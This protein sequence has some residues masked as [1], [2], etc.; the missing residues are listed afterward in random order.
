MGGVRNIFWAIKANE[1]N[2]E[3]L[4]ACN[5]SIEKM[6]AKLHFNGTTFEQ[7]NLD[8]P[9]TVCTDNRCKTSEYDNAT[10]EHKIIYSQ[11]CH[12]HCH[13]TGIPLETVGEARLQQCW[14]MHGGSFQKSL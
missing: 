3:E 1:T 10:K 5:G 7:V 4:K 14:A 9:R 12:S 8:Y 6:K 2:L 13:L 11:I